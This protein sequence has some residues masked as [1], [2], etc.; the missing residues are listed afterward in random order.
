MGEY[1]K[2]V[3]WLVVTVGGVYGCMAVEY[4]VSN[5]AGSSIGGKLFDKQVGVDYAKETLGSAANF[6]LRLFQQNT[7]ADRKNVQEQVNV[8]VEMIDGIAYCSGDEIH[9][10]SSYIEQFSGDIKKE[11]TGIL[12]HEMTHLWQWDGNGQ[13]P[14]GLIEGI[15]DY[16]RLKAGYAADYW[17]LPGH[18]DNWNQ[19][20]DVTAH[21]LVYCNSI[22]NGFVAHLN[23]MMKITYSDTY[24]TQLLGKPVTQLWSDYK[25]KY[26]TN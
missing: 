7:V 12:Y 10:S 21:F 16:V 5:N 18:G 20:Y 14:S 25:F 26:G 23:N 6:T 1:L 3:V 17:G 9:L 19:G 22:R 2:A 15:A 11:I 4:D 13:A 24:F 8:I